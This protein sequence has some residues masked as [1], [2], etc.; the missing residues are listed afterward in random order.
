MNKDD[1]IKSRQNSHERKTMISTQVK[2][3]KGANYGKKKPK[4]ARGGTNGR[5]KST[6]F[7]LTRS[8][9]KRGLN[10]NNKYITVS[11]DEKSVLTQ[12]NKRIY[13]QPHLQLKNKS[14]TEIPGFTA[15]NTKL[16]KRRLVNKTK[17]DVPYKKRSQLEASLKMNSTRTKHHNDLPPKKAVNAALK[18]ISN[19]GYSVPKDM[20]MVITLVPDLNNKL[21]RKQSTQ[22]EKQNNNQYRV[23]KKV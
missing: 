14:Q 12:E 17:T 18:A 8:Q 15:R 3:K 5:I 20:K 13:R 16:F 22:R 9:T 6:T 7:K 21:N 23:R 2:K 11:Q 10:I 1:L 4:K 19:A